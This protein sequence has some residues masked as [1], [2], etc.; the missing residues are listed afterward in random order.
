M[1]TNINLT[2]RDGRKRTSTVAI[3]VADGTAANAL[4]TVVDGVSAGVLARRS[5]TTGL[6]NL[7]DAEAASEAIMIENGLRVYWNDATTGRSGFFTI[8]CPDIAALDVTDGVVNLADASVMAA[9]VTALE[10]NGR[11]PIDGNAITITKALVVG[12]G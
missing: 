10:T 11:S 2:I 6:A 3:P 12:R 7:S 4:D 1:A 9:L 8:P 5:V